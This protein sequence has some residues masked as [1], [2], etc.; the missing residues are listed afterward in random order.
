MTAL[1]QELGQYLDNPQVRQYLSMI[2]QAEGT[3]KGE[4]PYRVAF[5]GKSFDS[6]D[7]HPNIR[8]EFTQ[9]DG[10]KNFSTAAGAYQFLKPTWDDASA[11]LGLTDFGPRSQDLAAVYLLKKNGTLDAVAKGDYKTAIARDGRVWASLPSSPYA[12]NKRS[13]EFVE[14]SLGQ[15]GIIPAAHA[16]PGDSGGDLNAVPASRLLRALEK[17]RAADDQ[18]AVNDIIGALG[19]KLQK[20]YAQAQ[21]HNDT[22]AIAQFEQ[23]LGDIG[24]PV[25]RKTSAQP[26][27]APKAPA[28]TQASPASKQPVQNTAA[29]PDTPW[30]AKAGK[31]ADDFVRGAADT[32]TFGYADELAAKANELIGRGKYKE[33]LK[34]ERQKDADG[35]AARIAGQVA[36]GLMPSGVAIQAASGAGKL[37]RAGA[38][39]ATGAIQGGLYGTGTA[40]GDL[41]DRL[42]EG[43]KGAA[44][45]A[46]AGGA[47]SAV[48]PLT[49]SQKVDRFVDKAGSKGNAQ[50]DAEIIADLTKVA[51]N[52]TQRGVPLTAN[53]LNAVEN[54]YINDVTASLKKL[55][56]DSGIDV[57]PLKDAIQNRRVLSADE[58]DALRTN[59][60]GQAVADAITKAQRLRS[61]TAPEQSS[62]GLGKI[63][64]GV[65]AALPLPAPVHYALRNLLGGRQS[66]EQVAAKVMKDAGTAGRVLERL[67]ASEASRS[68]SALSDLANGAVAARMARAEAG[69]TARAASKVK[70]EATL[71]AEQQAQ[72]PTFILGLGN[73]LGAPRNEKQMKEFSHVLRAQMEASKVTKDAQAAEG[74]AAAAAARQKR[75]E[76]SKATRM[77][78]GGGY[79][80][81]LQGGASGLNLTSKEANQGLRALS[82]HPVLGNAASELRRTGL[83]KN[84]QEFYAL[85]NALRGMKEQG[86]GRPTAALSPPPGALSSAIRNPISYAENVRQAGVAF[87]KALAKA[88]TP[89]LA[90]LVQTIARTK[91]TAL[92]RELLT[93]ALANASGD[94]KAFLES[95]VKPLTGYGKK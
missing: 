14:Q 93:K 29:Q 30:Y 72:D 58:L 10:K 79:Q 18:A 17:A 24:Q 19:P 34:A 51:G 23:M 65:E 67:G 35:G 61:M 11:A 83:V 1:A 47:L 13:M 48:L 15:G 49:K 36:G 76:L 40:E 50:L 21:E 90:G 26:Q 53:Q 52:E 46:A 31:V 81:L 70:D 16:A 6:L 42:V 56:K 62:G 55:G 89:E 59:P 27:E 32:L 2:T 9:T 71:I 63:A 37:A 78:L 60:A 80:Q 69:K 88:P 85:Q 5:G 12:Q 33:N 64:R 91:S 86:F 44:V 8:T 68:T 39:A 45:G 87:D 75:N 84:E 95:V 43:A 66:R 57:A 38:G 22:D 82:N 28:Q 92:K 54:R 74:L 41:G 73:P 4:D 77:P 3:A 94:E 25:V 20:G 7:A